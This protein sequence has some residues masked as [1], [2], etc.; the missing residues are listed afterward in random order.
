MVTICNGFVTT[1]DHFSDLRK[2]ITICN[3]FGKLYV[4]GVPAIFIKL[5]SPNISKCKVFAMVV[6]S[7]S[8]PS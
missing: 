6:K 2:V 1:Y 5:F 4:F 7:T 8:Q 3:R